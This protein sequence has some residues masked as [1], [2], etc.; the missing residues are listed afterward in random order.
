MS[1]LEAINKTLGGIREDT[2]EL[3]RN[4]NKFFLEQQRG[5]LD[6]EEDRRE[7]AKMMAALGAAGAGTAAVRGAGTGSDS[8]SGGQGIMAA[9][10]AAWN[11]LPLWAKALLIPAVAPVKTVKAVKAVVTA[12]QKVGTK[13]GEGALRALSRKGDIDAADL[14]KSMLE[15]NRQKRVDKYL[16]GQDVDGIG[17]LAYKQ[18]QI[19]LENRRITNQNLK[20]LQSVS[21]S[22]GSPVGSGTS[23]KVP[24]VDAD[25]PKSMSNRPAL[26]ADVFIPNLELAS[27][28]RPLVDLLDDP[29]AKRALNMIQSELGVKYTVTPDGKIGAFTSDGKFLKAPVLEKAFDKLS[30]LAPKQAVKTTSSGPTTRGNRADAAVKAR[31]RAQRGVKIAGAIAAPGL[32]DLLLNAYVA[33]EDVTERARAEGRLAKD[34]EYNAM[35]AAG[36][37][38]RV[39]VRDIADLFSLGS[40]F[41]FG[42]EF[43]TQRGITKQRAIAR[44]LSDYMDKHGIGQDTMKYLGYVARVKGSSFDPVAY[45][46]YNEVKRTEWNNMTELERAKSMANDE[47]KL[48][49]GMMVGIRQQEKAEEAVREMVQANEKKRAEKAAAEQAAAEALMLAAGELGAAAQA[50]KSAAISGSKG[51]GG[52]MPSIKGSTKD[53]NF[54]KVEEVVKGSG[55]GHLLGAGM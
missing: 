7:R 30:T 42:T 47:L 39:V 11:K 50:W 8:G 10:A 36:F 33:G 19:D 35:L 27:K 40:N 18:M 26:M 48:G 24:G 46:L 34:A 21:P 29:E 45:Q 3:N 31:V 13:L 41:A 37:D 16:R 1:S 23:P 53:E 43:D 49:A 54:A 44:T 12:P 38:P 32:L 4:F 2:D 51:S 17:E 15:L 20:N 5:K 6:A 28:S 9:L 14:R 22:L 52:P 55:Y 25:L